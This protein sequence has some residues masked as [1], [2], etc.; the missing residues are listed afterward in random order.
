MR[1]SD[2]ELG[3]LQ[4]LLDASLARSTGHLRS[5][6]RP[7]RTLTAAQLAGVITGMC[8]L[9]VSSVTAAGEP[10][11]SAADGHFLHGCWVFSTE[12]S[13]AKAGHFA[14][15]PAISLAHLR[16]E[17][18]GVFTHGR[19][20]ELNPRGAP[21]DP[22]WPGILDHLTQHYG[23]SPLSWGDVVAY[24]VRP[25]WMVVFAADPAALLAEPG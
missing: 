18:L 14:A 25:Q 9:A 21:P 20:E 12:R 3:Q 5:I 23:S 10:R 6:V 8:T 1:E 15:R 22:Q 17:E 11:V 19:V 16:G 4:A 2:A 24:R 13:S 7:G